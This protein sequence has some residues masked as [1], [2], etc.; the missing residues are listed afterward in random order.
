MS[1]N[2]SGLGFLIQEDIM[3]NNQHKKIKGYDAFVKEL[4]RRWE[5]SDRA[6]IK[7]L[8][9]STQEYME[10]ASDLTKDELALI[11]AYVKR[12]LVELES[13]GDEFRD[14][15]FYREIKETVWGWLANITD[16]SQLEWHELATELEHRGEYKAG[17]VV[18]PGR[19]DCALCAH[20]NPVTHPEILT[21]CIECNH[22]HF[23]RRPLQP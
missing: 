22:T 17:E 1:N 9:D 7:E 6:N 8:V 3:D 5:H 21:S 19:Y 16:Q 4:R 18:G 14:S 11:A 2:S 13:S 10:A 12:D 20:S 15:L 23:L